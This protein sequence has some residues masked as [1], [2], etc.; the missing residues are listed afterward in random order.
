[1]ASKCIDNCVNIESDVHSLQKV[2]IYTNL[3]KWPMAEVEFVKSISHGNSQ[4]RTL[5][6]NNITCRQ[7][8]LRSYTFTR[9]ENEEEGGRGGG[10]TGDQLNRGEKKKSAETTKRGRRKKSKA[11]PC[12]AFVLSLSLFMYEL[13]K[14]I[15]VQDMAVVKKEMIQCNR[16]NTAGR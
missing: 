16:N 7:M 13:E 5:V 9:K 14:E 4:H 8:Y 15:V 11:T 2:T 3:H 10:K 12:R 6:M 1:M